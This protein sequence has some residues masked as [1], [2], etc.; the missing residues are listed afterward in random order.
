[1]R[2]TSRETRER[3]IRAAYDLFYARG[4]ARVGVD[5][6]AAAA[7]ITKRTL[8]AHFPSKDALAGAA[9]EQGQ[10]LAMER[11]DTWCEWLKQDPVTGISRAF[12]V[13]DAWVA[14]PRWAGSGFSRIAM[15]MADLP[16]HPVRRAAQQHK[17]KLEQR[18]AEALGDAGAAARLALVLE[19][20]LTLALISPG[21]RALAVARE[22]AIE[23]VTATRRDGT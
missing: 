22:M 4:F 15:E 1:M 3:I 9:A 8:Y 5:D 6:V 11:V 10:A 14:K 18:L 17:N 16:G 7:G 13:L 12:D 20:A 2:T 19:G 23:I 21:G